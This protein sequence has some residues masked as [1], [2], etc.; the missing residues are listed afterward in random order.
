MKTFKQFIKTKI[1]KVAPILIPVAPV[2]G[3]HSKKKPTKR[4]NEN[5]QEKAEVKYSN[6]TNH[7]EVRNADDWDNH[8]DNNHL[9]ANHHSV[10]DKLHIEHKEY[11]KA[12]P[13]GRVHD[14]TSNS[15]RLNGH[16]LERAKGSAY[17][18]A[19][20]HYYKH[21][22]DGIDK[23][24]EHEHGKAKHDIHLYHGTANWHPGKLAAKH[25]E[26]HV[27]SAAYLS[28]THY[29]KLARDYAHNG[30]ANSH[31]LHIH[32]KKGQKALHI[33]EHSAYPEEHETLLPRNTTLKIHPKPTVL[34]TGTKVWHA[35]IVDQD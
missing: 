31:I 30:G 28:T 11:K 33:G 6:Q 27:K 15:E 4:V 14:Y 24:F 9:G 8:H 19:D 26:G 2:H 20:H 10:S 16:L 1:K 25:P 21:H 5:L 23:A 17:A 29:K 3:T 35:H 13:E 32:V 7:P 22:I 34:H 18:E 12:D